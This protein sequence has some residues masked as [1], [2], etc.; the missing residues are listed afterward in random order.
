MSLK[1]TGSAEWR[2]TG[3]E[4]DGVLSTPSGQL[5]NTA[6]GLSQ[7][8]ENED[9]K[10]GTNPEEL[11][12]A[13]HAGCFCMALSFHIGGAGYTPT[14]LATEAVIHMRQEGVDWSFERI[15]LNLEAEIAG[16]D[17]STFQEVA[18]NAKNGCPV[19]MALSAVP[20]ELNARLV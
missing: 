15:V 9:G 1:R 4:G 11:I 3:L 10:A 14:R 16:I 13:A 20:I 5:S 12:A 6:Y 17:D 8:F 2:G 7:R 18:N 19:S